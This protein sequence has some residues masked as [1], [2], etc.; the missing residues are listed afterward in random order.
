MSRFLNKKLQGL[1]AYVPG[2]QPQNREY[3]KLNTNESPYPPSD[4]VISVLN[5]EAAE[6]L[7]LYSDPDG[8]NLRTLLAQN[9]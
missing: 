1:K 3:I 7:R 5:K 9:Y 8:K 2:E 6:N 4:G